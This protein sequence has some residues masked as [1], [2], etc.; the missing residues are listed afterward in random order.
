MAVGT[1][2]V[3]RVR[4]TL[5]ALALSALLGCSAP[6]AWVQVWGEE[7]SG[8]AGAP[9]DT[10]KWRYDTADGCDSGNCGWGKNENGY[11]SRGPDNIALNGQGQ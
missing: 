3:T 11:Y 2:P 5:A 8:V 7:F 9:V 1:G 6:S 10:T 4:H